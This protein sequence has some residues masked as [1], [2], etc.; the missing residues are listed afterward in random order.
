MVAG[1][2]E[3]P[4]AGGKMM[5]DLQEVDPARFAT[6]ALPVLKQLGGQEHPGGDYLVT[7]LLAAGFLPNALADPQLLGPGEAVAIARTACRIDPQVTIR[8]AHLLGKS[9]DDDGAGDSRLLEILEAVASTRSIILPLVARLID[10]PSA[11]VRSKAAL[12]IGKGNRNS[13][14]VE[15]QLGQADAR[16]RAN[17]VESLWGID[18]AAVRTVLWEAVK[19][20]H[21]RVA[22]NALLGL[23]RLGDPAVIP[24]ILE[25]LS[26]DS[27]AFRATAAWLI[28]ESGDPR[29]MASLVGAALA[30]RGPA[31]QNAVRALVRIK[32]KIARTL[33]SARLRVYLSDF[34]ELPD[35]T[36]LAHLA[37]VTGEGLPLQF[38]RATHLVVSEDSHIVTEYRLERL[39]QVRILATA[40]GI[41]RFTGDNAWREA[42]QGA[43][44]ECLARK[45]GSDPWVIVKYLP[46]ADLRMELEPVRPVSDRDLLA[47]AL[48]GPG[49]KAS[50]PCGALAA[51]SLMLLSSIQVPGA[52]RLIFV[53]DAGG[54]TGAMTLDAYHI[55]VERILREA[56]AARAAVHALVRADTSELVRVALKKICPATGG[57]LLRASSQEEVPD[58]LARLY[59]SHLDRSQ[60]T[61]RRPAEA[62]E[63]DAAGAP[64]PEVRVQVYTEQGYGEDRFPPAGSAA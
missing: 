63:P 36:R 14:W 22:G 32:T 26:H 23:Y 59:F 25:L 8:L 29:F 20:P 17:A 18:T 54:S 38:A 2:P 64:P 49:L 52:R 21:H 61:W 28:G 35:G 48:A 15:S 46:G 55:Y 47:R 41:P 3:S 50:A 19:D 44:L 12:L 58:L 7:L 5:R 40:L 11:R 53:A 39:P 4:V 31:R 27:D 42:V 16:V 51:L 62:P 24:R 6:A 33:E 30:G 9:G 60:L 1:F 34:R 37:V 45:R 10:H 56:Q 57:I 13:H 43:A